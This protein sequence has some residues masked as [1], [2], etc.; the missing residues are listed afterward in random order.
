M[1]LGFILGV[2]CACFSVFLCMTQSNRWGACVILLFNPILVLFRCIKYPTLTYYKNKT[3]VWTPIGLFVDNIE[4]A[5]SML[6]TGK[7]RSVWWCRSVKFTE[8][9]LITVYEI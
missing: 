6:I 1:L 4:W 8:G 7:E 9:R 3:R 5:L 2:V